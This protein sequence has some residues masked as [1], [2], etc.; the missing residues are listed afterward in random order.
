MADEKNTE[1]T[2]DQGV[3]GTPAD[4][5]LLLQM[6]I[7]RLMEGL[8]RRANPR[9]DP[10]LMKMA[11]GFLKPTKTGGFGESLG[12]AG[13]EYASEEEKQRERANL[14]Q[15]LQLELYQKQ[16]EMQ[17]E[18]AGSEFLDKFMSG[19]LA[20]AP[21]ATGADGAAL[22]SGGS[23]VDM[24]LSGSIRVTDDVL[25]AA[26]KAR[27]PKSTM[28]VLEK[29]QENQ[30]KQVEVEQKDL[31]TSEATL[32][33]VNEPVKV[34]VKTQREIAAL[35]SKA[36]RMEADGVPESEIKN[37][38]LDFY[39]KRGIGTVSTAGATTAK[40]GERTI[41]SPSQKAIEQQ[42]DV[43]SFKNE[44]EQLKK[45]V[46][47]LEKNRDNSGSLKSNAAAVYSIANDPSTAGA[48]GILSKP[49]LLPAIGTIVKEAVRIGDISI[50]IPAIEDAIRQAGGTEKQV[51]AARAVASNLASLE[52][53][54][55]QSIKGQ[56]QVSDAERQILRNVGPSISDSAKVASLKAE[57]L[58]TKAD[59]DAALAENFNAWR[60]Q[61]K[62]GT[63]TDYKATSDYKEL[64]Q[65]KEQRL[66]G[67]LEKYGYK[68]TKP[69]GSPATS[70]KPASQPGTLENVIRSKK[71]EV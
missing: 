69:T 62:Y 2:A 61:N 3:L 28:E 1:Q 18:Q 27:V 54:F 50:G 38:F 12:Y 8:N 15:K 58:I 11:A 35:E 17:Q 7:N 6:Q 66:Y 33:Y 43:E 19:K 68:V 71:A 9:F 52:L 47:Q 23:P 29:M 37:M 20:G 65:E 10:S 31:G 59:Y 22:P 51:N 14:E 4:G 53:A 34:T 55:S 41:I 16:Y 13:E 70:D 64:Y 39:A 42:K 26:R 63:Y 21:G 48:F 32:P 45:D 30:R 24:A 56:G 46:E 40:P 57:T 49:G 67:L 5:R 44:Q 25:L 36:A 60:K